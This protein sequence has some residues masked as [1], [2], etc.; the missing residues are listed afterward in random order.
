MRKLALALAL[1]STP[2][3]AQEDGNI[4]NGRCAI[5]HQRR[6]R[7]K[8]AHEYKQGRKPGREAKRDKRQILH[9]EHPRFFLFTFI[10]ATVR[11]NG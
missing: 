6:C 10:N 2:A 5:L 1:V 9:C 3:I 8:G 4:G 11:R 7:A